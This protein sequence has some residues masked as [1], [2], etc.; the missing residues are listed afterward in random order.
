MITPIDSPAPEPVEPIVYA[1]NG[2]GAA[3]NRVPLIRAALLL[4]TAGAVGTWLIGSAPVM[5]QTPIAQDLTSVAVRS[6]CT[7]QDRC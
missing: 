6:S 3:T 5:P 4:A 1:P 7:D 2:R